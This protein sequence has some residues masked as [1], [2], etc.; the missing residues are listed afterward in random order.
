[1]DQGSGGRRRFLFPLLL[2]CLCL[3]ALVLAYLATAAVRGVRLQDAMAADLHG[4]VGKV[5]RADPVLGFVTAPGIDA[6]DPVPL[7]APV[8]LHHDARGFRVA[9]GATPRAPGRRPRLLFL[10]DSFTYGRMV[11]AENTFA[12]LTAARLGGEALNA[13]VSGYGLAQ[14]VLRARQLI[15]DYRPDV[16]V[17]QYSPWLVAR[18]IDEFAPAETG[19]QERALHVPAPYYADGSPLRIAPPAFDATPEAALVPAARL[20]SVTAGRWSFFWRY[21]LPLTWH[22]DTR[23]AGFRLRQWLGAAPRPT[24]DEAAVI[25]DAYAEL[26]ALAARHHA[27]LLILALGSSAPLEV[28]GEL[29]PPHVGGV[30]GWRV[31]VEPLVPQTAAEYERQY[32]TWRG[33]P[34]Q[35]VDWHPNEHAHRL[36]AEA[37]ATRIRMGL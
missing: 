25:R 29:F 34:P 10:G 30:N 24:T 11:A 37:L 7:G 14:M 6:F 32:M 22:Q 26:A 8:P 19:S 36:I 1:M 5:Y 28:P 35:L 17:V 27:R 23:L 31:L 3:A 18:S 4:S 2:A 13:G 33:N 16:V 21:A 9:G 20:A 15:P 12:D